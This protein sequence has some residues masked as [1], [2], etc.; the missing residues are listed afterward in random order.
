MI[1]QPGR[2]RLAATLSYRDVVLRPVKSIYSTVRV[3][4]W[5]AFLILLALWAIATLSWPLARDQGDF[6]WAGSVILKGGVLYNDAWDV[7]GP[8]AVSMFAL[9]QW[10]FGH[11]MWGIRVFDL[12]IGLVNLIALA[13]VALR[14]WDRKAAKYAAVLGALFAT[15]LNFT[16]SSQPDS[17][18]GCIVTIVVAVVSA[19][20]R[21]TLLV[22]AIAS[23][24][25]GVCCLEKP[26]YGVFI[27]LLVPFIERNGRGIFEAILTAAIGLSVPIFATLVY[28]GMHH[29]AGN[30][31]NT[32]LLFN[33]RAHLKLGASPLDQIRTFFYAWQAFLPLS[34]G[35]PLAM[36]GAV[37]LIT[38]NTR[39][40]MLYLLWFSLNLLV[41]IIQGKYFEYQWVP[42]VAPV[43]LGAGVGLRQL[44]EFRPAA[45]TAVLVA[46]VLLFINGPLRSVKEWALYRE[47][48]MSRD[49]YDAH[50]VYLNKNHFDALTIRRLAAYVQEHSA[51]N[52]TIQVWGFD[53]GINYL[54][55][56]G[57]PS[58]FG[59]T[60]PLQ[61]GKSNPYQDSYRAEFLE[62]IRSRP[63][64]YV[65]VPSGDA[66]GL[67]P[68]PSD[69]SFND[70]TAF[71]DFVRAHYDDEKRLANW[72]LYRLRGQ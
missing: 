68:V 46:F 41:L 54:A 67:M 20:P 19:R 29:A 5:A 66:F 72:T 17:W 51:T 13:I 22:I 14:F 39:F 24:L 55:N 6:A 21:V 12:L 70:F 53:A 7:K 25:V 8:F 49:D 57:T 35:V 71:R 18:C 9:A 33:L 56:R 32:Y 27:L 23:F 42:L 44:R 11:N 59:Y 58:R 61:I 43:A 38:R 30:L 60:Y 28:F 65:L 3:C 4:A 62:K 63:P 36:F 26:V 1:P 52:D 47:G 16:I 15:W 69:Q 48:K 40:G 10:V 50:F 45:A 37:V 64:R 31:V 34:A 2:V